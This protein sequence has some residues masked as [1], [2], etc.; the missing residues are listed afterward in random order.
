MDMED[1]HEKRFLITY[2]RIELS[3]LG[4]TI[5]FLGKLSFT[6]GSYSKKHS[7]KEKK[8]IIQIVEVNWKQLLI[9]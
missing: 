1:L 3:K 6:Y 7:V 2:Y 8:K 9:I 5:F 4:T